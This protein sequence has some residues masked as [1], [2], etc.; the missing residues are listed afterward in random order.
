MTK[1]AIIS[2]FAFSM[3]ACNDDET[4]ACNE[5]IWFEDLDK[6]GRGNPD[7]VIRS[8]EQPQGYVDNND[9]DNDSIACAGNVRTWY[10]DAD[11]DGLGN[12]DKPLV[13]CEQP[14]GFVGN[15]DDLNDNPDTT[16]EVEI[17]KPGFYDSYILLN[18][19]QKDKIRMIDRLGNSVAIWDLGEG[20]A[21]ANDAKL[22]QDG[23]FLSTLKVNPPPF[24]QGGYGGKVEIRNAQKELIWEYLMSSVD[25]LQHHDALQLP[26][27]N[28]LVMA[29]EQKTRDELDAKGYIGEH[30]TIN[31]ESIYEINP[32]NSEIVWQWHSW[33]HL[34]QDQDETKEDYGVIGENP[35]KINVNYV[36]ND[37]FMHAN[38][39]DYDENRDIIYL[40]VRYYSEVWV[41]D[42]NTTTEDAAG[43]M[44]DLIYRFGNPETF[45]GTGE[46]LLHL[47]H[48]PNL[49]KGDQPG[50]GN[51]I[52]FS[53]E[54]QEGEQS[55][56]IE[57]D[58]PEVFDFNEQPTVVWRFSDADLYSDILSGT[59][60]LPNGN[61][62]IS[63]GTQ[64]TV[65]EVTPEKEVV[66]KFRMASEIGSPPR[67]WRSYSYDKDSPAVE[68]I[69]L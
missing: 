13:A 20:N 67:L 18:E 57:L 52:V 63:V 32:S 16:A 64:G 65:W 54:D 68:A 26:N 4:P 31:A 47:Q 41:V 11:E 62:L 46:R 1:A 58:L 10:L 23:S 5:V 49:L 39:I 43:E 66:W 19:L 30:A 27:G 7:I 53:N 2:Y 50:A 34:V 35:G 29:W 61:T 6:D 9:D 15:D 24:S 44:G 38:G 22:L 37:R 17:Y 8:C 12:P 56:V 45:G 3:I 42:H 36:L 14:E 25:A 51:M 40:S 69:G 33:D 28:I 21:L 59:D 48:H 60:R 55:A